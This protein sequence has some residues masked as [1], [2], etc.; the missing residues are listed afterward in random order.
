MQILRPQ[1]LLSQSLSLRVVPGAKLAPEW[2]CSLRAQSRPAPVAL[3]THT[4]LR[5]AALTLAPWEHVGFL[6]PLTL[7]FTAHARIGSIPPLH[8]LP[9]VTHSFSSAGG[10]VWAQELGES[11]IGGRA[12]AG[13][14][15]LLYPPP[16]SL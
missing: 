2:F 15:S 12:V 10:E 13:S 11:R 8:S 9:P 6:L 14:Y 5:Q 16:G 7:A 1:A 3:S 4:H